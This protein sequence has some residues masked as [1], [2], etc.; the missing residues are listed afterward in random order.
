MSCFQLSMCVLCQHLLTAPNPSHFHAMNI[1]MQGCVALVVELVGVDTLQ[2]RVH[3]SSSTSRP[4]VCKFPFFQLITSSRLL[5]SEVEYRRSDQLHW[6]N[7]FTS[8]L[9][10]GH[11]EPRSSSYQFSGQPGNILQ[12][13]VSYNPHSLFWCC[14]DV[15]RKEKCQKEIKTF[16]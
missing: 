8:I 12:S 6:M 13:A 11:Y 5:L 1:W 15:F 10:V 9:A 2:R 16:D 14:W 4:P 3:I 7:T